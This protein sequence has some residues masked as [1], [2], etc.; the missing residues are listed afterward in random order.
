MGGFLMILG[1]AVGAFLSGVVVYGGM[2]TR[3]K[4]AIDG[5]V[6]AERNKG[7]VICNARVGEIEATHNAAVARATEEA[8][9]A[10]AAVPETPAD[11]DELKALCRASSSCRSRG[12]L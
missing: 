2:L 5:A 1:G 10:A 8:G 11:T 4:I 7:V 6:I 12:S 3:E 9:T